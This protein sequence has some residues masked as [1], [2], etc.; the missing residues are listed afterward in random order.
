MAFLQY[1]QRPVN[2]KQMQCPV[3]VIFMSYPVDCP[4]LTY[5]YVGIYN[6]LSKFTCPLLIRRIRQA[7]EAQKPG[8]YTRTN[9]IRVSDR[10]DRLFLR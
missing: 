2:G 7:V 9:P 10:S 3:M 6:M 8:G 4:T 5:Q 1:C